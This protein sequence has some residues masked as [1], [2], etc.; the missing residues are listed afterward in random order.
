M[1]TP[2]FTTEIFKNK[3]PDECAEIANEVLDNLIADMPVVY[4]SWSGVY[5]HFGES[6]TD[7]NDSNATYTARLFDLRKIGES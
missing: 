1:R 4:G 5:R 7:K 2:V 6:Y 3:R